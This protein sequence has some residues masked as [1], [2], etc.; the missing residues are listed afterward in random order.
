MSSIAVAGNLAP[1]SRA[2][3]GGW[4]ASP[5]F[6]LLFFV[7]GPLLTIPIISGGLLG[8]KWLATG[9][10]MTLAFAHY[11]S[12]Y[13]FYFWDDNR[14]YHRSRWLAFFGGPILIAT[15]YTVL[16][17]F[18]VP[19]IIQFI[20]FFW[21]TFHV[22]RQN[23]GILSVYRHRAG[24]TD[25]MQRNAA[26]RAI[27][28]VSTFLAV[29]NIDT[30]REVAAIFNGISS[31]FGRFVVIGAGVVA[32][33]AVVQLAYVLIKRYG[34]GA[35]KI[36]VAEGAFLFASLAFF[37]PYLFINNS[38]MATFVMLQPHFVQY[39]ALVWLLHR[40]KFGT[41][42]QGAPSWLRL[43][44]SKVSVLIPTLF[45]VGFSFYAL[46]RVARHFGHP[47]DFERLYLLIAL[48]HFYIDGLVWSFR[49]RHIRSTIGP[50]LLPSSAAA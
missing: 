22:A 19:Y 16:I 8:I 36:G 1:Q 6:D 2:V 13:A 26:N 20:L 25:A 30:H 42:E 17:A 47:I 14:Q 21:N 34:D 7:F 33:A 31:Q 37:Y 28:S 41:S 40:R 29:W 45:L 12:S 43:I 3:R 49:Q 50:Y 39:I 27:L 24:V 48:E 4:I 44:S 35:Q 23:C 11:M 46:Y 32:A 10:G 5:S 18:G 15:A 38:E 9:G